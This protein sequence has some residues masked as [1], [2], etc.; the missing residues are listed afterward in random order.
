MKDGAMRYVISTQG[1]GKAPCL[2]SNITIIYSGRLMSNGTVFDSAVNPVSFPLNNLIIGWKLGLLAVSK[3]AT[4]TLYIPSG[5]AYGSVAKKDATG[6]TII[7]ADSNLI[8]DISLIDFS[9]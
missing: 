6:K 4:I 1:T 9:N 3:G 7:P 5:Y 8:F 2:E